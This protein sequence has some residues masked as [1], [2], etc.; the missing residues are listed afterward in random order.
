MAYSLTLKM[1]VICISKCQL[2][3]SG[4]HNGIPRKLEP[5]VVTTVRTSIQNYEM[6]ILGLASI[7]KTQMLILD[8]GVM[9]LLLT[10]VKS[11][12]LVIP[13]MCV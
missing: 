5:F 10:S 2:T 9:H 8:H 6:F 11:L 13:H 3:F 4:L 7:N 12:T 1:E